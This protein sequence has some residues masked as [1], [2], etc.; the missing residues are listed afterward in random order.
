MCTNVTQ[1]LEKHTTTYHITMQSL[2]MG[3]FKNTFHTCSFSFRRAYRSEPTSC[4][5]MHLS[6]E[7][8]AGGGTSWKGIAPPPPRQYIS[9]WATYL[10]PHPEKTDPHPTSQEYAP[11]EGGRHLAGMHACLQLQATNVRHLLVV[12]SRYSYTCPF[13]R[14]PKSHPLI[15]PSFHT[16]LHFIFAVKS[17]L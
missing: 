17:C 10:A 7:H 6:V 13:H 5:H 15:F 12:Q 1:C 8:W 2:Q 9:T 11:W 3:S 16:F 4:F 14:I